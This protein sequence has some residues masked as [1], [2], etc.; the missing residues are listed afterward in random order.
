MRRFVFILFFVLL[1]F[2]FQFI[3]IFRTLTWRWVTWSFLFDRTMHRDWTIDHLSFGFAPSTTIYLVVEFFPQLIWH[4]M[5]TIELLVV[6]AVW[7][8]STRRRVWDGGNPCCREEGERDYV[9]AGHIE[10]CACWVD[11]IGEVD[12]ERIIGAGR[13][14]FR[15]HVKL[16]KYLRSTILP[17][18]TEINKQLYRSFAVELDLSSDFWLE[19]E[20]SPRHQFDKMNV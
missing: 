4:L 2:R 13:W 5:M 8:Q 14:N 7:F 10:C 1:D 15:F 16:N 12:V 17:F 9:R 3:P 18:R 20:W 11:R 19:F 6:C